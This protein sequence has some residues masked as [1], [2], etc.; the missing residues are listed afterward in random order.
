M[1]VQSTRGGVHAFLRLESLQAAHLPL[2]RLE[3]H[4]HLHGPCSGAIAPGFSELGQQLRHGRCRVEGGEL[5][6]ASPEIGM[7][8]RQAA[9]K[10][11][12]LSLFHPAGEIGAIP[13]GGGAQPPQTRGGL[14][15]PL[16]LEKGLGQQ[17]LEQGSMQRQR[18]VV[19]AFLGHHLEN[20]QKRGCVSQGIEE[21]EPVLRLA[22]IEL[23]V[24]GVH[25]LKVAVLLNPAT[26]LA[27][28][29]G[30]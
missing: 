11:L 23:P 28:G 26:D 14:W 21:L 7:F 3:A 25:L 18:A 13:P 19:V 27:R 9:G 2:T 30:L 15:V 10:A 24:P 16:S 22:G 20:P 6:P 8:Q 29:Q 5:Q 1:P 12:D 17:G 4:L